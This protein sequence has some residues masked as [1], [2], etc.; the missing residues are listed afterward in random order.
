MVHPWA[1][2]FDQSVYFMPISIINFW[3]YYII[4]DKVIDLV[5]YIQKFITQE[6]AHF[7]LSLNGSS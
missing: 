7:E 3:S 1:K 4:Y 6:T 5:D 2:T